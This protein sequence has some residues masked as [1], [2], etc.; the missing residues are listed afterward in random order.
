M[1]SVT[2][3]DKNRIPEL[4]EQ[5]RYLSTCK[6]EIGVFGDQDSEIL[7]I[8][9][10]HEFG[11]KIRVTEKMRN[12]LHSIESEYGDTV[13]NTWLHLK[14]TTQFINIPERSYIRTGLDDNVDKITSYAGEMLEKVMSL[15]WTGKKMLGRLGAYI[16][17]LIQKQIREKDEPPLHPFTIEHKTK[18]SDKPLVDTGRLRGSITW[19]IV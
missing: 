10:V 13:E 19:R 14:K 17:S 2:I 16:V 9:S 15:E 18:N 11:C 6:L 5:L 7:M 12:Y 8:A 1:G 3:E 4:I